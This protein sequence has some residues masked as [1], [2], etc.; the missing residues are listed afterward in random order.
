MKRETANTYMD[1][2]SILDESHCIDC[3]IT[4]DDFNTN[5]PNLYRI[6]YIASDINRHLK[7]KGDNLNVVRY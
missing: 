6:N 5:R 2:Q 7:S 1:Y 3:T 4:E